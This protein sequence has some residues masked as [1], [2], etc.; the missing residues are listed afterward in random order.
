MES[1]MSRRSAVHVP[2]VAGIDLNYRPSDYF[3]AA[4]LKISL[5]SG[6][7]GEARRHLIKNWIEA[8]TSIPEGLDAAVLDEE[9]RSTWGRIHP[10]HMGGEYLLPLRDGEV[11]IARI[12]LRSITADQISIRA[13]RSRRRIGYCVVDEYPDTSKYTC[14]PANSVAPLSFGELVALM[15]T[16][17][18]RGSIIFPILAMNAR[19]GS[20]ASELANFV[21]VS[22][23]FYAELRPYYRALT[24]AWLEKQRAFRKS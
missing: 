13:R 6:I 21:A 18:D 12:S 14:R 5:P 9:T 1:T 2:Q 15:E 10:S 16:A 4:D 11:E 23:D 19:H 7:A 8:G 17:K 3:W 24:S 22:S 20:S